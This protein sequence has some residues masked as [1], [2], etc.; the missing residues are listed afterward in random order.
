M[1]NYHGLFTLNNNI[2]KQEQTREEKKASIDSF[3]CTSSILSMTKLL[4]NS[5]AQPT[6]YR[7]LLK[8]LF[9]SNS[10]LIGLEFTFKY[11][12]SC[13]PINVIFLTEIKFIIKLIFGI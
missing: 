4:E 10:F 12:K 2:T 5:V 13:S 8:Y 7:F 1:V 11:E 3:S 6:E 9:W